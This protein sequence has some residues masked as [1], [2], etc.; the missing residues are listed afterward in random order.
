M[1]KKFRFLLLVIIVF[2]FSGLF[3]SIVHLVIKELKAKAL[4][5]PLIFASYNTPSQ[6]ITILGTV[7][8]EEYKKGKILILARKKSKK[9]E[10]PDVASTWISQPGKFTLKVPKNIGSLYID[11]VNVDESWEEKFPLSLTAIYGSYQTN[12][13]HVGSFD[14]NNIDI[15]LKELRKPLMDVY[16]GPTVEISGTVRFREYSK[17]LILI[18][19]RTYPFVKGLPDVAISELS[20]PGKFTLKVPKNIGSLYIDAVNVDESW[21]RNSPMLNSTPTGSYLEDPIKITSSNI[22][23]IDI[24]I[25]EI[26]PPL[27]DV[28]KGPTVEI[29]GKIIFKINK[30]E[31]VMI[32]ARSKNNYI[33]KDRTSPDIAVKEFFLPGKYILWVPKNA[34]EVYLEIV[35]FKG[36]IHSMSSQSIV[37]SSEYLKNPLKVG[38]EDIKNID[39]ILKN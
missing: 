25:Q 20:S 23:G 8:F 2:I 18:L 1:D 11:A 38:S 36:D 6:A 10:L 37:S 12:P 29:T 39:V 4:K 21:N 35:R 9:R 15:T 7:N 31:K 30:T 24:T 5:T 17:G 16:K 34:G 13:I 32:I 22:S 33:Y 14:I 28:Y 3:I 19:A 27:M 26:T